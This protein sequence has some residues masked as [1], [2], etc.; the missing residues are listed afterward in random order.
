MKARHQ[1]PSTVPDPKV[2]EQWITFDGKRGQI[3]DVTDTQVLVW[4]RWGKCEHI[5]YT[6]EAFKCGWR[7]LEQE[8]P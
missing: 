4:A 7:P 8:Q 6:H 5:V 2:G 1:N 3:L